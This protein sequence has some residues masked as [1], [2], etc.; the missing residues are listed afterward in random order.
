MVPKISTDGEETGQLLPMAALLRNYSTLIVVAGLAFGWA[1]VISL[2]LSRQEYV[3]FTIPL[4]VILYVM[5][6]SIQS[7]RMTVEGGETGE[8]LSGF[9]LTGSLAVFSSFGALAIAN[10]VEVRIRVCQSVFLFAAVYAV[11]NILEYFLNPE[12]SIRSFQRR[13]YGVATHPNHLG[14][15]CALLFNFFVFT[16]W[17]GWARIAAYGVSAALLFSL[18]VSGSRSAIILVAIGV[19]AGYA[20]RPLGI[21]GQKILLTS[22]LAVPVVALVAIMIDW[23][24]SSSSESN[25]AFDRLTSTADTRSEALSSMWEDFM[26]NPMLG[27]G[28]GVV[29]SENS[30]LRCLARTGMLGGVF[31]IGHLLAT[32]ILLVLA[33]ARRNSPRLLQLCL[34]LLVGLLFHGLL[35]GELVDRRS[36]LVFFWWGLLG[37][38]SLLPRHEISIEIRP[39][40]PLAY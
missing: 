26:E 12:E 11:L 8:L 5:F 34:A 16:R 14:A 23:S 10:S 39:D 2:V 7:I 13:F 4:V 36:V 24:S 37:G 29:S 31:F 15:T 20:A 17:R 9:L 22:I 32:L 27:S 30:V 21:R 1:A 3:R 38:I 33:F 35:E 28:R 25:G 19:G 18:I 40:D 6:H